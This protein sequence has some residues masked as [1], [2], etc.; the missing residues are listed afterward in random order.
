MKINNVKRQ[1]KIIG[2]GKTKCLVLKFS[3]DTT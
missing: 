2:G 3:K 1:N